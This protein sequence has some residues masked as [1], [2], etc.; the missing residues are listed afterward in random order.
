MVKGFTAR[1]RLFCMLA[2]SL[3][4]L[5]G[6]SIVAGQEAYWDYHHT[7]GHNLA[8]GVTLCAALAAFS[9]RR[10][11]GFAVYLLLFHLHL[12][13]AARRVG[14]LLLAEHHRRLCAARVDALD[15]AAA[16]AYAAGGGHAAAGPAAGRLPPAARGVATPGRGFVT[17][18]RYTKYSN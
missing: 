12:V 2:A 5:D 16:G 9:T 14:V 4:D 10:L 7:L 15:R 3:A 18:P 13:G 1:E 6:L 17:A 8:F 11:L